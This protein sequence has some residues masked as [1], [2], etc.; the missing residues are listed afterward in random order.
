M[1]AAAGG[2]LKSAAAAG[3]MGKRFSGATLEAGLP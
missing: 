3:F 1:S 2:R